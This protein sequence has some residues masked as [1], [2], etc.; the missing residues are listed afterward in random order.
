MSES[1]AEELFVFEE[2]PFAGPSRPAAENLESVSKFVRARKGKMK[3]AHDGFI[4]FLNKTV[5]SLVSYIS[6]YTCTNLPILFD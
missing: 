6:Q 4:Y 1:E 2:E 3:L 5:S